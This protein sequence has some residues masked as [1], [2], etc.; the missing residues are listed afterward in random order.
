VELGLHF[1]A[2]ASVA[3]ELVQRL[4]DSGDTHEGVGRAVYDLL[5]AGGVS[6]VAS[7]VRGGA[8]AIEARYAGPGLAAVQRLFAEGGVQA[9][10]DATLV[11]MVAAYG[12]A[13]S[14]SSLPYAGLIQRLFGHHDIS[15][16]RAHTRGAALQANALMGSDAYAVGSHVAF[17]GS[18]DL[19]T[20]AH[21]AAHVIQQRY[22][23]S[24]PGGVGQIG[25]RYERHAD[26]VADLIVQGQSAETLLDSMSGAAGAGAPSAPAAP[27]GGP[28]Q[29]KSEGDLGDNLTENLSA[30]N[31]Q[32]RRKFPLP[33]TGG[34][35]PLDRHFQSI[36][37][38]KKSSS[39]STLDGSA[40][41]SSDGA[42]ASGSLAS[43]QVKSGDLTAKG[44][45]GSGKA[46]AGTDDEG[47]T[48][49]GVEGKVA[50]GSVEYGERGKGQYGKVDA[51]VAGVEAGASH[52]KDK[53]FSVGAEAFAVQGGV[54][55]GNIGEGSRDEETR[56]S[57]G[58]GLG[59]SARGH[60]EDADGD[61]KR[62]YGAGFDVGPVTID[63]KTEDPL[64]YAIKGSNPVLGKV[65]DK[66]L[67]KD[68][69]LTHSSGAA[70]V[71]DGAIKGSGEAVD[72]LKKAGAKFA[73][74][75]IKGALLAGG[76]GA[77]KSITSLGKG[78]LSG[79]KTLGK[80]VVSGAK[81]VAKGAKKAATT[82][83]DG[84]KKAGKA[85]AS[86]AKKVG[87]ALTSW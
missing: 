20:V 47:N 34:I 40:S 21:E 46:F 85:V 23:V 65:F 41:A 84:A 9:H 7:R 82:V 28:V 8:S 74:G 39:G 37:S 60:W 30:A 55:Q 50:G 13:G 18:V 12:V 70:D 2:P 35:G 33:K 10:G 44:E 83:A 45:V 29:G 25:D 36:L 86:T 22:G 38:G 64:M 77:V 69:N 72:G 27:S 16:I 49:V 53:G 66:A 1:G 48:G 58:V 26:A 73:K 76:K 81:T 43:G 11:P 56:L 67:P 14:G 19:H 31:V 52:N 5:A 87:K 59:A 15:G 61:G 32:F 79:A 51:D 80:G 6:D 62:E 78:A 63:I 71:L 54:T 4:L 3:A 75:D 57:G 42:S 68:F 24:L 17:G